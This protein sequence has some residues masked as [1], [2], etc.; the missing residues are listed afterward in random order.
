MASCC[1]VCRIGLVIGV[2]G[3]LGWL[4]V[5]MIY[6]FEDSKLSF[7]IQWCVFFVTN[8]LKNNKADIK[9]NQ[10]IKYSSI[11]LEYDDIYISIKQSTLIP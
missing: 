3:G 1:D 10:D 5:Y 4:S 2:L 8:K 9:E 6:R 11:R 7:H